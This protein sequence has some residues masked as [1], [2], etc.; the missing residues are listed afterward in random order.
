MLP[1]DRLRTVYDETDEVKERVAEVVYRFVFRSLN[2][3]H[4]FNGDPTRATI[5]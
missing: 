1:D 5:C 4:V 3:L 2:R